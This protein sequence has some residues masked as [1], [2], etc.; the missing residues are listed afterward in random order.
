MAGPKAHKVKD[1]IDMTITILKMTDTDARVN[2]I[3]IRQVT[4]ANIRLEKATE[5]RPL[6]QVAITLRA[7][8]IVV[9]P[10]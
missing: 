4:D 8:S 2:L 7:I 1:T 9:I 5:A 3:A 6:G 10:M